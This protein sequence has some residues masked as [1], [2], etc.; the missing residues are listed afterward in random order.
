M[1]SLQRLSSMIRNQMVESEWVAR[2]KDIIIKGRTVGEL[3]ETA[4]DRWTRKQR[5]LLVRKL[6]ESPDRIREECGEI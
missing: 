5:Y 3:N 1:I 6:F 4:A 2:L